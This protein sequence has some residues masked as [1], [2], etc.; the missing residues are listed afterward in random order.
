M[1]DNVTDEFFNYLLITKNF[2]E[3]TLPT[4]RTHLRQF[5]EAES[6]KLPAEITYD[7]A[8]HYM[9]DRRQE[10]IS[11]NTNALFMN[12]LRCFLFFCNKRGYTKAQMDLFETP[13]R[14]RPRIEWVTPEELNAMVDALG[15]ERDRLILL[16]FYTSGCRIGEI[17]QMS[18]ENFRES[19]FTVQAKG[20]KQ[21]TYYF[22]RT[23]AD[24]LRAFMQMERIST[25]PI[26]RK[27]TGQPIH[28]PAVAHM[29]KKAAR[30]A[31]LGR[32]VSSHKLR[33]GFATT[34]FENG[35][36]MRD[37]QEQLGHENI[38][39]TQIY[40]HVSDKRQQESHDRFAPKVYTPTPVMPQFDMFPSHYKN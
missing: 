5:F 7:K 22:D 17:I 12:A 14:K 8:E 34:S 16:V 9:A 13:R 4:Y 37:L 26:F 38:Q 33:H 35:M 30:L 1:L 3:R 25:G 27:T 36:D 32:D 31:K 11:Q 20:D 28:A 18:A 40:T 23:V 24:R 39:T 19:K 2:S 10:G 15:R 21:H 29:V 6:I